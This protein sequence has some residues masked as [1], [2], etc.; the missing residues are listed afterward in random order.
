MLCNVGIMRRERVALDDAM[1]GNM[2]VYVWRRWWWSL[3]SWIVYNAFI[4]QLLSWHSHYY[5]YIYHVNVYIRLE[6]GK[7]WV[8]YIIIYRNRSTFFVRGCVCVCRSFPLFSSLWLISELLSIQPS[9]SYCYLFHLLGLIFYRI[10]Y[11][12]L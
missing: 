12:L 3:Q 2:C 4:F 6:T 8:W 7:R 11:I 1:E 5:E 10:F 9:I